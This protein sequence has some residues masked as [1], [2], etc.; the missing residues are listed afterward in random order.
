MSSAKLRICKVFS[1]KSQALVLQATRDQSP[2]SRTRVA[3]QT[4]MTLQAVSRTVSPLIEKKILIE[5][6]LADT[7]GLRRKPA[8]TLN[9]DIGYCIAINYDAFGLEGCILDSA[10]NILTQLSKKI[11]LQDLSVKEIIQKIFSFTEELL[12][13]K[14]KAKGDCFG[15]SVVDPGIIDMETRT[16]LY[17]STLPNWENVQIADILEKKFHL[18]VMLLSGSVAHILAV[19]RLEQKESVANLLYIKYGNGIGCSIKLQNLYI[20]GKSN[21]AG[22]FGHLHISNDAIPCR[23]GSIGCLEATAAFPA[24]VRNVNYALKKGSNSI[25]KNIKAIDGQAIMKAAAENDPLATRVVFDAFAI[26]GR[27]VGGLINILSPEVVLL[28]NSIKIAGPDALS[29]L[30]QAIKQNVI[31]A[32]LDNLKIQVSSLKSHISCLGGA[33]ALLDHCLCES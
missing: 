32:H 3:Q 22:E 6:P 4:G 9:P 33:V 1:N 30:T 24:L 29:A 12:T 5:T 27:A 28:D 31:S 19:D 25:L 18:P 13:S 10:Y 26:L 20:S 8:L 2:I 21:L 14:P 23:C 11:A 15:L 17:C 7:S 16:A